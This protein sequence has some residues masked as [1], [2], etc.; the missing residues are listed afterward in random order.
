M[1]LVQTDIYDNSITFSTIFII[2]QTFLIFLVFDC[3]SGKT[4]LM[5]WTLCAQFTILTRK[6]V[7]KTD[8]R[9][10]VP[11]LN[12]M[13]A[14]EF[15]TNSNVA[16]QDLIQFI[17]RI[18]IKRKFLIE[19]Y[20]GGEKIFC[21]HIMAS[22]LCRIACPWKAHWFLF[23]HLSEQKQQNNDDAAASN[24]IRFLSRWWWTQ[25]LAKWNICYD[26]FLISFC[27]PS[28]RGV[29]FRRI[30]QNLNNLWQ[31]QY[32]CSQSSLSLPLLLSLSLY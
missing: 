20:F 4:R 19:W 7:W 11:M 13:Y 26:T 12:K 28:W 14:D 2:R 9:K 6:Q 27:P 15:S 5:I 32:N 22:T 30:C 24:A 23:A 8:N 21:E 18:Q 17:Q 29:L 25:K 10:R 3:L 1:E 31:R 16:G